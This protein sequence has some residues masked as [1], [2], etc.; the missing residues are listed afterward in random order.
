MAR[1]RVFLA[2]DHAPLVDL[3]KRLLEPE[4]E[5]VGI[6]FDGSQLLADAPQAQPDVV[7]VDLSL[8]LLNGMEAGNELKKLLPHTKILV[9]TVNEDSAVASKAL[10]E[11]ASGYLLKKYAGVELIHAIKELLNG[12]DYLT[13]T[14]VR[15]LNDGSSPHSGR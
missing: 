12:R 3:F 11:W 10:S 7:I 1:H 9:V 14:M 13:P 8:L 4:F 15:K 5:I 2:D 6:A